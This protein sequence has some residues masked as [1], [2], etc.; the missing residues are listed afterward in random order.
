[1]GAHPTLKGGGMMGAYPTLKGGGM[2][3]A[4]FI[5]GGNFFSFGIRGY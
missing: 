4:P 2:R 1:M 5:K 3:N